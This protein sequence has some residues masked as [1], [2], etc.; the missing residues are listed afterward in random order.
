MSY[1]KLGTR[2]GVDYGIEDGEAV[3]KYMGA[4]LMFHPQDLR[5]I[6]D[7]VEEAFEEATDE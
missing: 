1:E 5:D 2:H 7:D 4:E 3:L 6:A